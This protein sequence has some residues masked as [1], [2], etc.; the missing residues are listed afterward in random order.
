MEGEMTRDEA[1]LAIGRMMLARVEKDAG[2]GELTELRLQQVL[3][4]IGTE[5]LV[6]RHPA[7]TPGHP[8]ATRGIT[9]GEN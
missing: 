3:D 5:D 4:M 9:P 1:A 6:G 7:W 2:T 8:R